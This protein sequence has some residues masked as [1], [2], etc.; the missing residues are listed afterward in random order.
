MNYATSNLICS[1]VLG[2]RFEYN[3]TDF[4]LLITAVNETLQQT[5]PLLSFVPIFK[6]LRYSTLKSIVKR[7]QMVVKFLIETV[8]EHKK[9]HVPCDPCDY[10]DVYL[11]EIEH[12]KESDTDSSVNEIT[13]P[14]TA[15]G[16][17][18]AG[19]DTTATTLRWAVLYMAAFPEI[20]DRIHQELDS[21]T[22]RNH[23]PRLA[24]KEEL[25][26]TCATL[27]EIQRIATIAPLGLPHKC[28]E[29]STLGRYT[30]PKGAIIIANLW[31]IHH[32][33]DSWP[34]PDEF[35]P[36]RFLDSGGNVKDK[37]EIIPFGTGNYLLLSQTFAT[38]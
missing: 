5:N 32:D 34:N 1:V 36:E 10:I 31:A 21:V 3:D 20:Q 19:T 26:F 23:L 11:D 9:D 33:P 24:D 4:K 8:N 18:L 37:E 27:L 28:A 17:F 12:R 16:L 38:Y 14:A 7:R 6:Y 15:F 2:K 35:K 29:D 22:G 25:S 13:L 30:I